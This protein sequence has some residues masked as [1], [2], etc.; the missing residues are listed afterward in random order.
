M[1]LLM[2]VA[3]SYLMPVFHRPEKA[4]VSAPTAFPTP[5]PTPSA[6]PVPAETPAQPTPAATPT[7]EQTQAA[8]A[9]AALLA[10]LPKATPTP[11]RQQA[12]LES[13]IADIVA[14]ARALRDRGDAITAI[15]RLRSAQTL[16]PNHTAIIS[17]MAITYEKMG[18]TEKA[19]EQWRRIMEMGEGAGIYYVAAEAKLRVLQMPPLAA[20]GTPV[21]RPVVGSLTPDV[22]AESQPVLS[23]GQ[24]GTTDD[25]GNTQPQRRLKLRVPIRA[26]QGKIEPRDVVIQVF[27]YEQLKDGSVVETNANVTSSWAR[28]MNAEGD[29]QPVDWSTPEPEV[30]EVEY[31]QPE[32]D[33]KDPRTRERRNYFG[34]SVRVYYKG[35]LNAKSAEPAKLIN[36]FIPPST[37]PSSDLPQ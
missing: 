7:E 27:F 4:P 11:T 8:D 15:V 34:Y 23:L 6:T 18:L 17:E 24:V 21:L 19:M 25:T 33:P 9:E 12:T 30:L 29:V 16:A 1:I 35:Q 10:S 2:A 26:S 13:R 36:Q 28:R 14:A 3:A 32:F 20:E 37:L 31:A 22:A 5:T